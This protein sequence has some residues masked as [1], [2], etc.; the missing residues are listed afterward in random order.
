MMRKR[1]SGFFIAAGL[2]CSAAVFA[3]EA[4]TTKAVNLRAGPA[5]DYPLVAQLAAG[6]PVTVAGCVS[7][8]LWCDVIYGDVRGWAY[9]QSLQYAYQNRQVPIYGYG[10]AIGLPIVAFSVLSYW[11]NYYRDRPFY[12]DRPRWENR[13]Y[14]AGPGFVAPLRAR[15]PQYRPQRPVQ[16]QYRASRPVEPQ[17]RQPRIERPQVQRPQQIQRPQQVQ[18]QMR[19]Q[20][21][22]QMRPPGG[23]EGNR[24]ASGGERPIDRTPSRDSGQN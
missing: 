1:F 8:Y 13:P 15:E 17:F 19:P 11:D 18:P 3:Q 20:V 22:P 5:R 9:A 6:T 24:P 2:L 21:Q 4:Y 7:D 16:P 23:R 10:A 14:R 12:R